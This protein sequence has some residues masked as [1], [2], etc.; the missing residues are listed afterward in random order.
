[1]WIIVLSTLVFLGLVLY[2]PFLRDLFHFGFLHP[3]DILMCL[4]AGVISVMWFEA[5]KLVYGRKARR[6]NL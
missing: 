5:F 6:G 2:V 4:G 3:V 1:L